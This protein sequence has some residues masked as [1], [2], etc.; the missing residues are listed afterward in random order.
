[1]LWLLIPKHEL[2][3]AVKE[4]RVFENELHDFEL[5]GLLKVLEGQMFRQLGTSWFSV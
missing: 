2:V 4:V 5:V 3:D 1:M